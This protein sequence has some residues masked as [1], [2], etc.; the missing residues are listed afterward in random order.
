LDE[1]K[2]RE[3]IVS[4]LDLVQISGA[5]KTSHLLMVEYPNMAALDTINEKI[6][7]ASQ[8]VLGKPFSEALVDF[9]KMRDYL[10]TEFYGAPIP[11]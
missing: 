4:Y 11:Q 2:K 3:V 7:E 8:K 10:R 1:L 6:A 5:G 9:P